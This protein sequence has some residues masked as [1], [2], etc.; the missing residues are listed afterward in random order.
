MNEYEQQAA[1]LLDD[2][3][4]MTKMAF[5]TPADQGAYNGMVQMLLALGYD[6]IMSGGK[7]RVF[8]TKED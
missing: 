5:A 3:L 1:Q 7:H 8:D 2:K 4:A 6:T